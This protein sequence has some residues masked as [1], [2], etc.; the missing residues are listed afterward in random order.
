MEMGED[1]MT[2]NVGEASE[3]LE[4]EEDRDKVGV[5]RT[6]SRVQLPSRK[7]VFED[8]GL[9]KEDLASLRRKFPF[10]V[11]F[12]DNFIRT[13]TTGD[14]LKMES[15]AMKMR[16]MERST[17]YDDK[18]AMNRMSLEDDVRMVQ[19][20][21]D[22]RWT[23]LHAGRFLPGM[24]CTARKMW[25]TARSEVG[26]TGAKPVG[27]YD[28]SA[29][30]MGGFVTNR[31][32]CELAN[33]SSSKISLRMFS[34]NNCG[35]KVGQGK[36]S[37]AVN[38]DAEL[39]DIVELGEFKVAL[40]A[41]RIAMSFVSPWNYSIVALENFLIQSNFCQVDIGNLTQQAQI[42]TQFVDYVLGENSNKW[43]D[44]EPFLD[45][46]ALKGHWDSFFAARPQSSVAAKFR[47]KENGQQKQKQQQG[48]PAIPAL[49]KRAWVDICFGWNVNKCSKQA[50]TCMS[51][52]GTPLRHV[53]NFIADP[54]K[55]NAYC[56]KAH[57]RVGNH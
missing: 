2:M 14:L 30:G 3:Y 22:N 51:S 38:R 16:M 54:N 4:D 1:T 11:D 56:E 52:R 9:A 48:G 32:W 42:L 43:R 53:C 55:P 24:A 25:L 36:L 19:A 33:P 17:D 27:C 44:S 7:R 13:Q 28:M 34:I 21:E 8:T 5:D 39:E 41:L 10:L 6:S 29:V 45:T 37:G 35:A 26:L 23:K 46:S 12:T 31:G 20:G 57:P 40:R 49:A 15:T 18:L 47:Q 50:G